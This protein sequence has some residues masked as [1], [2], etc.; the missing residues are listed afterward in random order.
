MALA[1]RRIRFFYQLQ[2]SI[3]EFSSQTKFSYFLLCKIEKLKL[4]DVHFC[5]HLLVSRWYCGYKLVWM[6]SCYAPATL[7]LR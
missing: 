7:S 6:L 3:K 5:E 1:F 2:A 4:W